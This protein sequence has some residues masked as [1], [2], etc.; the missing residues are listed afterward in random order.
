M[1]KP[2]ENSVLLQQLQWRYAV[3]KFDASRVVSDADWQTLQ[4]ALVLTPSSY[5][6]QPW[7]FV[8]IT[9]SALKGQ[10]PPISWGQ[11]QVRDASHVVVLAVRDPFGQP[12]I[13]RFVARTA[14]VRGISTDALAGMRKMMMQGLL[15]PGFSTLEWATR[16]VYIALGNLM[17]SAAMLG[18]DTCPMEGIEAEKYDALLNLPAT[19]YRTAVVC[20]IGYRTNDDKYANLAKVR[21]PADTVVV[22]R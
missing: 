16:Q 9:D 17:T 10:L 18:I 7:Q 3:K 22:H 6:L 20:P 5:G 15:A 11:N 4:Q 21:F 14:E 8:V 2:V 1:S 19:G 12:D 13:D